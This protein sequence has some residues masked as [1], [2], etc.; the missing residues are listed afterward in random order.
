MKQLIFFHY[1]LLDF[2]TFFTQNLFVGQV[3]QFSLLV[4]DNVDARLNAGIDDR[5]FAIVWTVLVTY[6]IS[7]ANSVLL[8]ELVM[9]FYD[10][11]SSVW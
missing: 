9:D 5:F 3:F 11:P 1:L 4:F 7:D 6:F 2:E 10:T 8:M